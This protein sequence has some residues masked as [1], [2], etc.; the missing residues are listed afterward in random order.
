MIIIDNN[1]TISDI[2]LK[3][4]LMSFA[5]CS[6][7]YLCYLYDISLCVHAGKVMCCRINGHISVLVSE[8]M[9]VLFVS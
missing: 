2:S 9:N 7:I 3:N 4:V 5:G 1:V 6:N 8:I